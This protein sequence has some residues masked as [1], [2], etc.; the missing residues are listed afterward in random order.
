MKS[1]PMINGI[2]DYGEQKNLLEMRGVGWEHMV[3]S[4]NA[5]RVWNFTK[6]AEMGAKIG[7]NKTELQ[8]WK[9]KADTI[10]AN[11]RKELWDE[12]AGWFHL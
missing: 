10:A 11:I 5:E 7:Y 3:P 2:V 1:G 4:P 8:Q 12:K 6:L 9:Q